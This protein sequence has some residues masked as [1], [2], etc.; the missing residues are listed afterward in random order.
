MAWMN[1]QYEVILPNW[2]GLRSTGEN[3]VSPTVY[4]PPGRACS[5]VPQARIPGTSWP[6][7]MLAALQV[8]PDSAVAAIATVMAVGVPGVRRLL[9]KSFWT[10]SVLR[11]LGVSG[12]AQQAASC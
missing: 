9:I 5:V 3:S 1:P 7:V 11:W 12:H 4:A 10:E 8:P 2:V 6:A